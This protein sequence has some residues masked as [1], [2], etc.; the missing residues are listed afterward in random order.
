MELGILA[1]M[2]AGIG[3]GS[4]AWPL[5]I[6]KKLQFEHAW[7]TGMLMG[8]IVMPWF[9]TLAFCPNAIQAYRDV[10]VKVLILSN[11][12]SLAWGIAMLL[13]G[14]CVVRIGAALTGAILTGAAVSIG[15]ITPMII[16][17]SGLF[18]G[19][20]DV[21]SPAGIVVIFGVV[22]ML[23]GVVIASAAGFAKEQ[24]ASGMAKTQGGFLGGMLMCIIAGVL[25]CGAGF[26]F[27]YSQGP[28]VVAM[29]Q[30]GANEIPA[31]VSVWAMGLSAGGLI[32]VLHPAYII[33]KKKSWNVITENLKEIALS[34]MIGIQFLT[35]IVISGRGMLLLGALGASVGMGIQQ[36]G[37]IMSN[38]GVGFASG[39]WTGVHGRPIRLMWTSIAVLLI[40]AVIM[41]YG[42]TLA[43]K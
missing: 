20:P 10:P 36:A 15:V 27:I 28:I 4:I 12:F 1:V 24:A 17:G 33:S 25:S 5:K 30:H 39:E 31:S 7:F 13:Y 22:I 40:A 16:K 43:G 11:M 14:I 42:N 34:S 37:Q 3:T 26:A 38:A 41:A 6:V 21:T 19:A 9:I 35:A 32:N 29:K 8:L 18:Y 2:L 23:L